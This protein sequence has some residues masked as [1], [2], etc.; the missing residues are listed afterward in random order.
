MP[1]TPKRMFEFEQSTPDIEQSS[2]RGRP[3]RPK[4][5]EKYAPI[6]R[7]DEIR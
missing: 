7:A 3:R 1:W 2:R 6:E 4:P 5:Y